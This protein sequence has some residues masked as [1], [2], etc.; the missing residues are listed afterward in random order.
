MK[1][2]RR[3]IQGIHDIRWQEERAGGLISVCK[4]K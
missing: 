1:A 2:G 3:K 4:N